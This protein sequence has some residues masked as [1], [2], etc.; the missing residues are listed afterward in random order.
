MTQLHVH[1]V[2]VYSTNIYYAKAKDKSTKLGKADKLTIQQVAVTFL[3]YAHPVDG[4]IL[5]AL[6]AIS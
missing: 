5:V 3:Y 2:P 1:A 6:S 4:T